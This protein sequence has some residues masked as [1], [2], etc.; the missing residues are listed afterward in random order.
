MLLELALLLALP[1]CRTKQTLGNIILSY[2]K[3]NEYCMDCPNFRVDIRDGGHVNFE[4]FG[5]CAVP[6]GQHFLGPA[7]RFAELVQA[8]H[9]ARF[10]AI[11]RTDP[12]RIVTDVPVIVLT[13]RDEQRIHEVVDVARRMPQLTGL[14][15]RMLSASEVDRYFKPSVA[16]YRRLLDSGWNVNTLGSGDQQNALYFAVEERDSECTRF[17][18]QHGSNVTDPT[19]DAAARSEN[20]EI[21]RLV[22]Q[23]SD[24]KLSGV[25]GAD[26]LGQAARSRKTDL[27]QFLLD[28]GAAVNSHGRGSGST[29]LMSAVANRSWANA[30]L[31]LSK[32]ADV[33]ARD[34]DG[35]TALMSIAGLGDTG[36][37][38]LLVEHGAD[39]N[40]RDNQGRTALMYA[41]DLCATWNLPTLLTAGADPAIRDKR[42]RTAREP[43]SVSIGDPK[44]ATASKMIETAVRSRPAARQG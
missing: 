15:N 8:F 5:A 20:L 18:L 7:Q 9:D 24:P 13:Y 36:L 4:C 30:R 44:C 43:N 34:Q 19:L 35:R 3:T 38:T 10:F 12:K 28:A 16:L 23:A 29:P 17:L 2:S 14:E 33:N 32:G 39:V 21:L 25:R 41:A 37:I 27:V 22:F 26:L 6:G 31:F 11:P 1:G 40:A 42:G